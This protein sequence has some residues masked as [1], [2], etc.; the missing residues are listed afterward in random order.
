[1]RALFRTAPA[2]E[3]ATPVGTAALPGVATIPTVVA[4]VRGDGAPAAR[5]V[6]AWAGTAAPRRPERRP[7]RGSVC[8][9]AAA[10]QPGVWGV[11]VGKVMAAERGVVR[12][13]IPPSAAAVGVVPPVVRFE[14]LRGAVCPAVAR[15]ALLGVVTTDEES[16]SAAGVPSRGPLVAVR[17]VRPA[18]GVRWAGGCIE[19]PGV[20][21]VPGVP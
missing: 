4:G 16:P 9:L 10:S 21:K 2:P 8:V 3:A 12:E 6:G 13:A 18:A 14:V 7:L 5:G 20:A 19:A 1:L 15:T 11:R 17:G